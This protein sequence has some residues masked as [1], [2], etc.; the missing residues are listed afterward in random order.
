[1]N[2]K[3][4]WFIVL[5][6]VFTSCRKEGTATWFMIQNYSPYKL[7]CI[8]YPKNPNTDLYNT[9][10]SIGSS[11]IASHDVPITFHGEPNADNHFLTTLNSLYDSIH[12]QLNNPA[13]TILS[14]NS[15]Q[16]K[17]YRMNMFTDSTFWQSKTTEFHGDNIRGQRERVNEWIFAIN[18][19]MIDSL[20][21]F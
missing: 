4:V 21:D 13:N 10:V 7:T 20:G 3:N 17:H 19:D 18:T 6:I 15:K 2:M 5:I 16:V 9:I 1:M 14:F 8:L 12:I 11:P